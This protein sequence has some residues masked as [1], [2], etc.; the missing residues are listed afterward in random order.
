M[1]NM[2]LRFSA[3]MAAMM[4]TS[5]AMAQLNDSI[6]TDTTLWFNQTQQLGGVVV[7]GRLP[8]TRVKG[9][10]MRTIVAGTIL[11]KAGTVSDALSKIPSVKAE[12]GGSVEVTGRGA[13]EVYING[14]RV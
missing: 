12:R 1:K 5:M 14:R 13:A 7:K 11:E 9:D 2:N 10:A 8:K 6:S 3:L 4:M